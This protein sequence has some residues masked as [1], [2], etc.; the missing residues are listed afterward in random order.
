MAWGEGAVDVDVGAGGGIAGDEGG[1]GCALG[2]E[3]AGFIGG[4]LCEEDA[5]ARDS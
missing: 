3:A 4:G 5:G 2:V 1:S